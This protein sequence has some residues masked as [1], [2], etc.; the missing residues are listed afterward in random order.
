MAAHITEISFYGC[1]LETP[2][3]STTQTRILLKIFTEQYFE[4][5]ATAIYV[6]SS[7]MGLGFR[8]GKPSFSNHLTKVGS[9]RNEPREN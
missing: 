3:P 1:Y 6:S 5:K 8:E 9:C 4:A 7:R 2:A